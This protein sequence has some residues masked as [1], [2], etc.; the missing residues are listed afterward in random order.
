MKFNK[1]L[2]DK[3][4]P[5]S[6]NKIN[7]TKLDRLNQD[8]KEKSRDRYVADKRQTKE[9]RRGF[10][11]HISL[12]SF[13]LDEDT[14]DTISSLACSIEDMVKIIK[15]GGDVKADVKSIVDQLSTSSSVISHELLENL[16]CLSNKFVGSVDSVAMKIPFLVFISAI[17]W[18]CA[19]KDAVEYKQIVQILIAVGGMY[20]TPIIVSTIT[21]YLDTIIFDN[22][23][24]A[25]QSV[26]E[27]RYNFVCCFMTC[28]S[29]LACKRSLPRD[30]IKSFFQS[31]SSFPK[32]RDGLLE[33][34]VWV[35]DLAK[36]I[37]KYIAGDYLGYD[38][39]EEIVINEPVIMK[40]CESVNAIV[41]ESRNTV[42]WK[43]NSY[44]GERLFALY[45]QGNAYILQFR[46]L[47]ENV[48]LKNS[49]MYF[50]R[51]LDKLMIPFKQ[52]NICDAGP[53]MEPL[54]ILLEG[55]TGVN[56][57]KTTIPLIN[58][59]V[60]SV[61]PIGQLEEFKQNYMDFIYMRN[62]EN[63]YW[64]GYRGQF[65][66]VFDDFGQIRDSVGR[67]DSEF[68]DMIRGSN[69][70]PAPL[71]TASLESKGNTMFTS[72]VIVGT[73]NLSDFKIVSLICPEAIARRF[74][75][76][77]AMAPKPEFSRTDTIQKN[78]RNR[79]LDTTNPIVMRPQFNPEL[80]EFWFINPLDSTQADG[81]HSYDY[82]VANC[83]SRFKFK[84][85]YATA[86]LSDLKDRQFEHLAQRI[87]SLQVEGLMPHV[88]APSS[89]GVRVEWV[90]EIV[91][92]QTTGSYRRGSKIDLDL[93]DL[94]IYNENLN[95][96]VH[97]DLMKKLLPRKDY[98]KFIAIF[99]EDLR[100]LFRVDI[101]DV[102]KVFLSF[103]TLTS[104][105]WG[106]L[107]ATNT[108]VTYLNF[109]LS[110][111]RSQKWNSVI[112]VMN[113][114]Y[115]SLTDDEVCEM[116]KH[117]SFLKCVFQQFKERLSNKYRE[118]PLLF[119]S[120]GLLTNFTMIFL[121][122]KLFGFASSSLGKKLGFSTNTCS[123]DSEELVC[124]LIQVDDEVSFSSL[125]EP[126][127][128]SG[129]KS[130][131][132]KEQKKIRK[133]QNV[134]VFTQRGGF[135]PH[136]GKDL[137]LEQLFT[138][139]AQK[140]IFE[141]ISP[142][143]KSRAGYITFT[144]D[145]F[146]VMNKH[147][148]TWVKNIIEEDGWF[149][150]LELINRISDKKII[151]PTTN[152]LAYKASPAFADQDLV[153]CF[154]GSLLYPMPDIRK[155]FVTE[156]MLSKLNLV[157]AIV[158]KP[159]DG[160]VRVFNC[161][162]RPIE[163]IKVDNVGDGK[164]DVEYVIRRGYTFKGHLT[165]G[166]CG[167]VLLVNNSAVGPGKIMGF[168]AAGNTSNVAVATSVVREDID[169]CLKL[170]EQE[171][172]SPH[173]LSR[174]K[175]PFSGNFE[176]VERVRKKVV[177]PDRESIIPSSMYAA[178]GPAKTMP[179]ITDKL[180]FEGRLIRPQVLALAEYGEVDPCIDQ[181]FCSEVME[182]MFS[183]L[184]N[185]SS[186]I[187]DFDRSILSVQ[188]SILGI[189]ERG[190]NSI[191]RQTSPGYPF[192]LERSSKFPG[193]TYWFG[194][195]V[196]YDLTSVQCRELVN[197]VL[198]IISCAMDGKRLRHVF[199]DTAKKERR[200][201]D[202]VERGL[203][204]EF[205]A[206]PLD[207][208][209]AFRMYFMSF[210]DY[211][212]K[213]HTING[214]GVGINVYGEDWQLLGTLLEKS[215]IYICAGDYSKFDKKQI[216]KILWMMLPH[217]NK[218]YDDGSINAKIREILWYEVPNSLHLFEDILYYWQHALCSGHSGTVFINSFYN[219]FLI[220]YAF[221]RLH[222]KGLDSLNL[223]DDLVFL[224][225]YGDDNI[226]AIDSS[227]ISWFNQE[228]ISTVLLELN[229]V[230][231]MED[232]SGLS[233]PYRN[234]HDVTFLK[235]SFLWNKYLSRY[236]APLDLDVVLEMAYWTKK[237]AQR[238]DIEVQNVE[239]TLEELSLHGEA[240]FYEWSSKIARAS[241]EKAGYMPL[242]L[243][244]R[245]LLRRCVARDCVW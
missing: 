138:K 37:Y 13:G 44:N 184:L 235:R 104:D 28:L 210:F 130:R 23:G 92:M 131:G 220:M 173:I 27:Y 30:R 88:D 18:K 135:A 42:I 57:T 224:C 29:W 218:W 206:S 34:V 244:Y 204:R 80:Y 121:L 105:L 110:L 202:K 136:G 193:K 90:D 214:I 203:I 160:H 167:S 65:C 83:V 219:R 240:I 225:V 71:H 2:S 155:L 187:A 101:N 211:I 87:D 208:Q 98:S 133:V 58:E 181:P 67:T 33:I 174:P 233:V 12:G 115:F 238:R 100:F 14:R 127:N 231:T 209:I 178:W 227:I 85:N 164:F 147:Y 169:D 140:N 149:D 188:E 232:K 94:D 165:Q 168:H 226:M 239:N 137:N 97:S 106:K 154:A 122:F 241:I 143:T 119:Q 177:S 191:P 207:Y 11:P 171:S 213:N 52:A 4:P 146:F 158:V 102:E 10:S 156:S 59:I 170:F 124:D 139:I 216:A 93:D 245:T 31:C 72:K 68:L 86:Y 40:W 6:K 230:Y 197:R 118:H 109:C 159:D 145:R 114:K 69:M 17:L 21:N 64:D 7:L 186:P 198:N 129:V 16:N 24:Y 95:D 175:L 61:L 217:I 182:A 194:N 125:L 96:N 242:S 162:A 35:T 9:A 81:P 228:T 180:V 199:V 91:D 196:E 41:N 148:V 77:I 144:H 60:S 163:N 243:N 39:N 89:P 76:I 132:P 205:C 50:M 176:V 48:R 179:T 15:N 172:F 53:R 32:A 150:E 195:G 78:F 46:R 237:G 45:K 82:V 56:K 73:T 70:F 84:D 19:K 112:S 22:D 229:M 134:K 54:C 51:L 107:Y 79:R 113:M 153:L 62:P 185:K 183:S 161:V 8:A 38:Y 192:V 117:H 3:L 47:F 63:I 212:I 111:S 116:N 151:I 123:A 120:L 201:I 36:N 49:M 157:D 234:L 141:L 5:K 75:F 126:E 215:S 128:E 200:K 108:D 221:A 43:V 189:P 66:C 142:R 99:N 190:I 223:F 25:P 55:P 166:D 103:Y 74:D 20:V 1:L 26:D 152:F 222:E 236:V